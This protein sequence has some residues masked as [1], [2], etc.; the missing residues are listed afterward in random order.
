VF[1]VFNESAKF[2]QHL[3]VAWVVKK[4]SRR[5][6]SKRFKE[7]LQS[8]VSHRRFRQRAAV[9]ASR[10]SRLE[11]AM[12]RNEQET[13]GLFLYRSKRSPSHL[14]DRPS[15]E[16]ALALFLQFASEKGVSREDIL[17]ALQD[18]YPA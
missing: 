8:A 11:V 15:L 16:D 2:G 18:Y 10:L 7:G 13:R 4:N 17:D 14:F 5:C 3:T 6:N 9:Y 1:D 12:R